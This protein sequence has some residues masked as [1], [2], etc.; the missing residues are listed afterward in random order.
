MFEKGKT[1]H[2]VQP[3]AAVSP[4]TYIGSLSKSSLKIISDDRT[5]FRYEWPRYSSTS[6]EQQA[7]TR[8]DIPDASERSRVGTILLFESENFTIFPG[9]A[10][11]SPVR[12]QQ[13]VITFSPKLPQWIR[14]TAQLFSR[15]TGDRIAFVL[16][17][18]RL[19]AT[20]E[21]CI[22]HITVG[23]I[24][25]GDVQSYGVQLRNSGEPPFPFLADGE[26]TALP[27]LHFFTGG[28]PSFSGR[29]SAS[30]D[31]LHM[32]TTS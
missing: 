7:I 1:P 31:H 29:F 5:Q 21:F 13:I 24:C 11:V 10:A 30:S 32:S 8:C 19:P 9:A 4:P 23:H 25:L 12:S 26:G 3:V 20:G 14:E 15:D 22:E 28:W 27:Q 6:E 17:G 16:E 2:R 18:D